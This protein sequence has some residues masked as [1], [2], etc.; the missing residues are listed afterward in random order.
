M[1]EESSRQ[2][3]HPDS[4]SLHP[5]A[6]TE[7]HSIHRRPNDCELVMEE[8]KLTPPATVIEAAR[9]TIDAF[10]VANGLKAEFAKAVEPVEEIKGE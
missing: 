1:G 7:I 5:N 8:Q 6:S 9:T 2:V 4:R 3:S 10:R